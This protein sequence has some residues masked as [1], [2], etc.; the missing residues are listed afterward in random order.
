MGRAG[1]LLGG[2]PEVYASIFHFPSVVAAAA[3]EPGEGR[4]QNLLSLS[5]VVNSD[6]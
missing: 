2:S 6:V 3:C 4:F 5:S 1:L